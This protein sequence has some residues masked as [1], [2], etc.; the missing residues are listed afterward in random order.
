M[1][2]KILAY[3]VG[4]VCLVASPSM[5]AIN[6]YAAEAYSSNWTNEKEQAVEHVSDTVWEHA[7]E[8]AKWDNNRW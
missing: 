8:V 5:L 6:V 3:A 1:R 7:Q 4:A 2:N